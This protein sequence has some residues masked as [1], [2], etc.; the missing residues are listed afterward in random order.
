[1]FS[2]YFGHYLLNRGLI[3]REQLADALE[4]QKTVHVK[5]GVIAVDE[6]FMTTAQVEEVHE[7]QR[8]MDKRF[9]E[10]AVEL[11]YLTESQVEALISHQKQ[12]HLYLA[13]AL[14][15]REYMTIDEFGAALNEYK[16]ENSLSDEQFE[17]IRNGN[18]D[19]LVQQLLV[20]DEEKAAKYGRYLSL[21]A[22]NMI[23]FI[24]DQVYL[25]VSEDNNI[26]PSNWLIKQDI[27]GA[28]PLF[29]GISTDD[30][31]LLYIAS[32]YAEEELTQVDA[33]AKDAV[34]EFLN[35]HNGIYLV[36]MSN[37]GTELNMNPQ[38]IIENASISGELFT[39]NVVTA[40]GTFQLVL[41]D[42]TTN[43]KIESAAGTQT[44]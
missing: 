26:T 20:S 4:Y 8:Q 14:V 42:D 39:V 29:T 22:K 34:S 18:I 2:Q 36:N 3:T 33:F 37:W 38:Q 27:I 15:D 21:F 11:G 40:K 44:V 32:I 5:F 9:G 41:S 28:A 24:D 13:Q 6:G 16:K 1:M 7:K 12:S 10:I 25:E 23:R 43:I 17:A 30:Q 31:T 19:A 35:L